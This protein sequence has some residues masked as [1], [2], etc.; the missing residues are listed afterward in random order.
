MRRAGALPAS[1][2]RRPERLPPE[3]ESIG[4]FPE[5]V[6]GNCKPFWEAYRMREWN[7]GF[8]RAAMARD[9]PVVPVAILGG[10]ECVPVGWTVRLLEPVIGSILPLP[11]TLVPLPGRW[12]LVFHEP[13]VVRGVKTVAGEG[14]G[15]GPA[16]EA[17]R[18]MADPDFQSE[19]ARRVRRIVQ[20]TLDREALRFPLGRLSALTA[21]T[22]PPSTAPP[23]VDA[24]P[25]DR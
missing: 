15:G 11:L 18:A 21:R 13:V 5:G 12:K 22:R 20:G 24:D 2:F 6:R 7:R 1:W 23:G 9:A 14:R 8:V 17:K 19:V 25:L 16:A 3:V 4:I 10:E